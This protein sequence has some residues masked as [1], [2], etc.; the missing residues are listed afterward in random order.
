MYDLGDTVTLTARCLDSSG[1]LADATTATLTVTLPDGT[2]SGHSPTNPPTVTGTYTH[3]YITTQA[4]RHTHRWTFT[5]VVPDQAYVDVFHVWPTS[6][7]WI[8][9]L[10]ETKDALNIASTNTAHDDELRRTIAGVTAVVESIVGVVAVRSFTETLS[11]GS[12][13]LQLRYQPVLAITSVSE[14]G[15]ALTASDYKLRPG[16]ILTRVS[17]YRASRWPT[18]VSNISV[19][20]TAGRT[21]IPDNILDGTRDLIRFNFRPQLGG[22]YNAFD[23]AGSSAQR[24]PGHMV[25][26]FYV[27]NSVMERLNPSGLGPQVG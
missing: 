8:V 23:R 5:G 2:T 4:G 13:S 14:D 1:A 25:L 3:P 15:T 18:G 16:G 6:L 22:N 17:S 7:D 24:E 12:S 9:G 26:G 20:H 10:A 27:P 19:V 21:V 11:G